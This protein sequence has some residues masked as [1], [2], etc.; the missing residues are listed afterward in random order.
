M[1]RP[2]RAQGKTQ[3]IPRD[4]SINVVCGL[5]VQIFRPFRADRGREGSP[6]LKPWAE[7]Y[8]PSGASPGLERSRGRLHRAG[9]LGKTSAVRGGIVLQVLA[10]RCDHK[11]A[12]K[13]GL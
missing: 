8:S 4:D 3:S 5:D 7:G 12:P 10:V 6:G 2:E 13:K 1:T 11:L 9:D